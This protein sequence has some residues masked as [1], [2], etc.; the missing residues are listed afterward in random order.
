MFI[1]KEKRVKQIMREK[2][3]MNLLNDNEDKTAP[4]FVKL[5]YAFQTDTY[6]CI[7]YECNLISKK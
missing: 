3:V 6:L 7:L 1:A 5:A 2:E 4:F